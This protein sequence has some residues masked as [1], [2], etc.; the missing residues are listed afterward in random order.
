MAQLV[1]GLK[2]TSDRGGFS[3]GR[4][5]ILSRVL[6]IAAGIILDGVWAWLALG[7]AKDAV[8]SIASPLALCVIAASFLIPLLAARRDPLDLR[9]FALFPRAESQVAR[10]LLVSQLLSVETLLLGALGTVLVFAVHGAAATIAAVLAVGI[11]VVTAA[12]L[13]RMGRSLGG[14]LAESPRARSL[15]C[16]GTVIAVLIAV[17]ALMILTGFTFTAGAIRIV[18]G[19]ARRIGYLPGASIWSFPV[20]IGEG[21]YVAGGIQA[22]IAVV[23]AV[24]AVWGWRLLVGRL[25]HARPTARSTETVPGLGMFS[26]FA[27]NPTGSIAARS[28][29]Y[30]MRDARYRVPNIVIPIIPFVMLIPLAIVGVPLQILGLLPLPVVALF[31]GWS[32]HNDVAMDSTAFWL[33]VTSGVRGLA[34][35]V[36]RTIPVILIGAVVIAIGSLITAMI[37]GTTIQLPSVIGVSTALLLGSLGVSSVTS[38]SMPYGTVKPGESIFVMPSADE[39]R[40]ANAQLISFLTSILVAA[41]AIV[42]AVLAVTMSPAWNAIALAVGVGSGVLLLGLGVLIGGRVLDRRGPEILS[43]ALQN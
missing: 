22:A 37:V 40:A 17:P 8:A 16:G 4:A 3:R 1:L 15:T 35:R 39:G 43:Y 24:A 36:G 6:L 41:P 19:A 14:I 11:L 28:M 23:C 21:H 33:H 27:S 10:E 42:C 7:P 34:D 25:M 26:V 12:A 18:P 38:V 20:E 32:V 5:A 2:L 31:L 30:W 29:I 9:A 13:I